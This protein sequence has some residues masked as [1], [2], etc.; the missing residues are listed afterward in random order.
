MYQLATVRRRDR[1]GLTLIGFLQNLM[2]YSSKTNFKQ[3][4]E[5]RAGLGSKISV[6]PLDGNLETCFE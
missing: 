4:Q 5:S 6:V 1:H 2:S 3:V